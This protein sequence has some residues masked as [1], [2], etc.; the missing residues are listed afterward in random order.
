[1]IKNKYSINYLYKNSKSPFSRKYQEESFI[2]YESD[3]SILNNNTNSTIDSSYFQNHEVSDIGFKC[4]EKNTQFNIVEKNA[5]IRYK[6]EVDDFSNSV[7]VNESPPKHNT[8]SFDPILRKKLYQ[9]INIVKLLAFISTLLSLGAISSIVLLQ[10]RNPEIKIYSIQSDLQP[11]SS[12][13]INGYLFLAYS[14]TN[15]NFFPVQVLN[16]ETLDL[17]GT[18]NIL[19]TSLSPKSTDI[20]NSSVYIDF[21]KYA[22]QLSST[23]NTVPI[24]RNTNENSLESLLVNM[25]I[26]QSC[27]YK[28]ISFSYTGYIWLNC[29]N[30][31]F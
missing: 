18:G 27:F 17:V 15:K 29:S 21:S 3:V 31:F 24:C 26:I 10:F 28:K 30:M 20:L 12:D 4:K 6:Y 8:I 14:V 2:G 23:S 22:S 19:D 25:N 9:E 1:M 16:M 5:K 13:G 11:G 7:Y